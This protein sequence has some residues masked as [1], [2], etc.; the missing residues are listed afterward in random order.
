MS[1]GHTSSEKPRVIVIGGGISGLAAAHRLIERSKDAGTPL[2]VELF[3]ARDRLGG[4]IHTQTQDGFL[5][6]GGPDSFITQKPAGV[7]LCQ[8]L[9]IDDQ[10]IGTN[11]DYRRT[12]IA[13]NGKL[14]A[15]PEGFL[16]LAPTKIRPFILSSL[17]TWRGK[18]R[19]GM[20]LLIPRR[21][22]GERGD[23]SLASFVRRRF[24][25]EALER[26][27]QPLVGG[28][29]TSDPEKLSL[30][31]TMSRF[32]DMETQ[33]GSLIRGMR[34][35]SHAI[36]S[37]GSKADSGARYS[38]FISFK[39][40]MATLVDALAERIGNRNIHLNRSMRSIDRRD[41]KWHIRFGAD[42]PET[43]DAVV[44]ACPSYVAGDVLKERDAQLSRDLL[45]IEYASAAT[46]SMAFP[47]DSVRAKL[48]GFG[49]VVP[50]IERRSLI[51]VTFSSVKFAGRAPDGWVLMRA[52]VGGAMFPE[53]MALNDETMTQ[54]VCEDLR[55][56]LGV[57]APPR[58]T[59]ISRWQRSMPQYP[60]GHLDTVDRIH[61]RLGTLPGLALAG[62][63]FGGVGIPDCIASGEQAAEHVFKTLG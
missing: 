34:K 47:R 42:Q 50:A 59:I 54:R 44:L 18:L 46:V 60:V 28:I 21:D 56:F 5:I 45:G 25:K 52:F 36:A 57:E 24:G 53:M 19:M 7:A 6:E 1:A 11:P 16:L 35:Q 13:L 49:F 15:V 62:N 38:M 4:T 9:K 29:Y 55:D 23:E 51:A 17:F 22:H 26:V 20:D 2:R 8:R 58:F 37:H 63:A 43:A 40:G 14:H 3:E 61:A 33:H 48:D 30:R 32:L 12:L 41:G 10:L 31:T 39:R 27:A